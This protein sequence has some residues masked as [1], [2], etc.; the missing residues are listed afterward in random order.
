MAQC[1]PS[2][3]VSWRP[4]R[5]LF[6]HPL[7]S[8]LRKSARAALSRFPPTPWM[9]VPR[10]FRAQ[11]LALPFHAFLL[12][13]KG[14]VNF[15]AKSRVR[16]SLNFDTIG[17]DRMD[18]IDG[19]AMLGPQM[20]LRASPGAS[21]MIEIYNHL[22]DFTANC[23]FANMQGLSSRAM[24]SPPKAACAIAAWAASWSRRRCRG[25]RASLSER[26]STLLLFHVTFLCRRWVNK[27]WNPCVWLVSHFFCHEQIVARQSSH[28]YSS[29]STAPPH[30][31][32]TRACSAYEQGPHI[33]SA[34]L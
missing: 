3:L 29:R 12:T 7:A 25:C 27:G 18:G 4:P 9:L 30:R 23:F 34:L 24:P 26:A 6:E 16:R 33:F 15:K 8:S 17:H 10:R 19:V 11:L 13:F 14:S 28:A 22:F 31:R 5:L 1:L 2:C 32:R 20:L 21:K